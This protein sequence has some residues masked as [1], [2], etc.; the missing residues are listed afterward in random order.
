MVSNNQE[1]HEES[2]GDGLTNGGLERINSYC[3]NDAENARDLAAD[4]KKNDGA[5]QKVFD[6]KKRKKR[7]WITGSSGCAAAAMIFAGS[8][9]HYSNK[10]SIYSQ[11]LETA[12]TTISSSTI[13][14]RLVEKEKDALAEKA[15]SLEQEVIEANRQ[16]ESTKR[17]FLEKQKTSLSA[18]ELVGYSSNVEYKVE[19]KKGA[20]PYFK[21]SS[22]IRDKKVSNPENMLH[23]VF[24]VLARKKLKEALGANFSEEKYNSNTLDIIIGDLERPSAKIKYVNKGT[25]GSYEEKEDVFTPEQEK[26]IIDYLNTVK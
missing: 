6:D 20:H 23:Y 14:M 8:C 13:K 7:I 2:C 24:K 10:S 22:E 11:N 4:L 5:L 18:E 19:F 21:V 17:E 16:V 12:N 3:Q 25:D 9:M 1:K 26:I 15:S